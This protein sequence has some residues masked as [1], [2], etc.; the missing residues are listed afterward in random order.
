MKNILFVGRFFSPKILKIM[1]GAAN[2]FPGFSTHNYEIALI[3]GLQANNDVNLKTITCPSTYSYPHHNSKL[4]TPNDKFIIDEVEGY[5]VGLCNLVILNRIWAFLSTLYRIVKSFKS[6]KGEEVNIICNLASNAAAVALA[7]K[8]TSKKV[9]VTYMIL[10]IPQMVSSMNRM[11]PLKSYFVKLLNAGKMKL[12]S[13]SDG[14]ILMTEQMMDF[15][16]KPVKHI[17]VEGWVDSEGK[18]LKTVSDTGKKI[19]LYTGSLRKI[20]G[21]MNLIHALQ[22]IKDPDV[23]L[24]LCGSG[25]AEMEIRESAVKDKRIKFFGLVSS[26]RARELQNE[27]TIL[28]NPRTSEGEYTKYSFPSKILEYLL[29]GKPSIA[30]KLPGMPDEYLD[31][32]FVPDAESVEALAAKMTEVLDMDPVKRSAFGAKGREFVLRYKTPEVQMAKVYKMICSNN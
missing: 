17:V 16:S 5:S 23:E 21:V 7:S 1:R 4:F 10:D 6:F 32:L 13:N 30:Y 20:F 18:A 2:G 14:L 29:S 22:M 15:I 24:W 26:E 25:D 28:I 12:A 27:S 3:K 19:V 8:M 11:N 9:R 31:F